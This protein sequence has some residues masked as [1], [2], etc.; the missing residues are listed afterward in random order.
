MLVVVVLILAYEHQYI[1]VHLLHLLHLCLLIL[2]LHLIPLH[3]HYLVILEFPAVLVSIRHL[4]KLMYHPIHVNCHLLV[5]YMH[6]L[7]YYLML[8][9]HR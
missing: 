5:L 2:R 4:P 3:Q 9:D 8:E 7:A 6:H 1:Q